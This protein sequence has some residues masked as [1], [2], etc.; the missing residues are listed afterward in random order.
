MRSPANARRLLRAIRATGSRVTPRT[1]IEPKGKSGS[2]PGK[3]VRLPARHRD[4][5]L[6]LV[7][8]ADPGGADSIPDLGVSRTPFTGM[9]KPG[10]AKALVVVAKDQQRTSAD[11]PSF[12]QG[13]SR[14]LRIASCRYHYRLTAVGKSALAELHQA[15]TYGKRKPDRR[16]ALSTD[17]QRNRPGASRPQATLRPIAPA[18][19]KSVPG[20][21]LDHG[22]V[23]VIDYMATT[24][25]S[26][27]P[28]ASATAAAQRRSARIVG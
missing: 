2:R 19:E 8:E 20:G 28:P 14:Q 10:E 9:G 15:A 3:T 16:H 7:A 27:R 17:Q 21:V 11:L 22:F 25:P 1:L 4:Y 13:A 6:S 26:C 23:R 12:G 5:R 24:P 18:S